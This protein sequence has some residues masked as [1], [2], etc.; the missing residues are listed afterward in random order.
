[1]PHVVIAGKYNFIDIYTTFEKKMNKIESNTIIKYEDSFI[2]KDKN[3]I[4]IKTIVIENQQAQSIYIVVMKKEQ[5]ITIRLDPLTD[6]K[7]TIAI[8]RSLT[9][10]AKELLNKNKDLKV[11]K[12]NLSEFID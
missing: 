4:L 7:K 3:L 10:I 5:Q 2:N 6:P 12:T 1:M 11:T 9:V 8:K